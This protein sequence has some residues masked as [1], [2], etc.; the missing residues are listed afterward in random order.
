MPERN[1]Q[2]IADD[3]F[4]CI[5]R[6]KTKICFLIM[7]SLK[8]VPKYPINNNLTLAQE[9]LTRLNNLKILIWNH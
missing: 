2:H 3:I 9:D 4:K 5:F 7:I 6:K 1:G 8:F